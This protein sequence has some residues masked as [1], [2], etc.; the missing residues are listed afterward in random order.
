MANNTFPSK[1][2]YREDDH[3]ARVHNYT[4]IMMVFVYYSQ[5]LQTVSLGEGT[6]WHLSVFISCHKPF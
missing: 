4:T 5:L 1:L 3:L 2:Q 6:L